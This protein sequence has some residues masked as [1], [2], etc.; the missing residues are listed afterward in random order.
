MV[1]SFNAGL[2]I[3]LNIK[4]KIMK[5]L[6]ITLLTFI[7]AC[8]TTNLQ[9]QIDT[10][11]QKDIRRL[12]DISGSLGNAEMMMNT[13]I[14][15][16]EDLGLNIPEEFWE[17]FKKEFNTDDLAQMVIPIYAKYYTHE[18]IK[19]LIAFYESP[20]GQKLIENT[21][22]VLQESMEMGSKWGQEMAA[23]VVEK[24]SEREE[25]K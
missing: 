7:I 20:I 21:P 2:D 11:F 6:K 9:A 24:L 8:F 12:I 1:E 15:Q 13:M 14:S 18:D 22:M 19:A 3:Q 4:V 23:R 25:Q 10:S 5:S 17:E 16:Y